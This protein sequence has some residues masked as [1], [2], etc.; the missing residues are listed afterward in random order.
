VN[1]KE[2]AGEMMSKLYAADSLTADINIT[3]ES[4]SDTDIWDHLE[5]KR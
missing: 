4:V 1:A 2:K 3:D 5:G